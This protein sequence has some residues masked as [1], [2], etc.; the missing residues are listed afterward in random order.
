MLFKLSVNQIILNVSRFAQKHKAVILLKVAKA[1]N[2][3][4]F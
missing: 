4:D 1:S 3:H 2:Q